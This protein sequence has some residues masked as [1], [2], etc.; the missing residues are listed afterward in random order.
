MN[1]K[2]IGVSLSITVPPEKVG[3]VVARLASALTEMSTE[4]GPVRA[5]LSLWEEDE[6]DASDV[7]ELPRT[8][9]DDTA[10]EE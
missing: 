2:L 8:W 7:V 9:A 10:A 1:E 4:I 5:N 3:P 6:E